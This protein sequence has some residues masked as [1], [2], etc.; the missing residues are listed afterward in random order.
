MRGREGADVP[1]ELEGVC[2]VLERGPDELAIA[3]DGEGRAELGVDGHG[4]QARK[5]CLALLGREQAN[6]AFIN[7][8]RS[9]KKVVNQSLKVILS[10]DLS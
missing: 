3:A 4:A 10:Q 8:P 7:L 9:A 5:P 6:R 1:G 2:A